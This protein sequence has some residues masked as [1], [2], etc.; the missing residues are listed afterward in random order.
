LIFSI[1][2]IS[3]G[4]KKVNLFKLNQNIHTFEVIAHTH[5]QKLKA[6]FTE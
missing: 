3:W 4:K 2:C 6:D 1:V 5:T